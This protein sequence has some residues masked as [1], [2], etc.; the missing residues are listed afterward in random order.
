MSPSLLVPS[1]ELFWPTTASATQCRRH[2]LPSLHSAASAIFYIISALI[3]VFML[4]ESVPSILERN[5]MVETLRQQNLPAEVFEARKKEL[6][7]QFSLQRCPLYSPLTA[8]ARPVAGDRELQAEQASAL[9][10]RDGM[11]FA[12]LPCR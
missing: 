11:R 9:Q 8:R 2:S 7:H 1:W 6:L 4:P 12:R 3:S 5:R 10:L